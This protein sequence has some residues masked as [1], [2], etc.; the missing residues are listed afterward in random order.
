MTSFFNCLKCFKYRV[1][2]TR[3]NETHVARHNNQRIHKQQYYYIDHYTDHHIDH[4]EQQSPIDQREQQSHIYHQDYKME[5]NIFVAKKYESLYDNL[6]FLIVILTSIFI[7]YC[8]CWIC[9]TYYLAWLVILV[10]I[11]LFVLFYRNI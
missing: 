5:S 1:N 9:F 2:R 11:L 4:R 3:T 7:L 10:I 6:E 8:V